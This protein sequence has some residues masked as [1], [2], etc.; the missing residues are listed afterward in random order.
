MERYVRIEW[1]DSQKIMEH[2]KARLILEDGE[3]GSTY[4]VPE[5]V[6]ETY[7]DTYYDPDETVSDE[8]EEAVSA[9]LSS[10]S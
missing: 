7:K 6:W 9:N 8:P 3:P 5:D 4:V 1:P 2:P 10:N